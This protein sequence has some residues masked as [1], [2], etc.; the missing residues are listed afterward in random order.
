[1][2]AKKKIGRKAASPSRDQTSV[3][4]E[5][6]WFSFI[7]AHGSN[8]SWSGYV[9]SDGGPAIPGESDDGGSAEAGALA[10]GQN[11]GIW[12][13]IGVG[14]KAVIGCSKYEFVM[15]LTFSHLEECTHV[16]NVA[17]GSAL[18]AVGAGNQRSRVANAST[19]FVLVV[20]RC[21]PPVALAAVF[22]W[23][24]FFVLQCD[25][26]FCL[27][28]GTVSRILAVRII[29]FCYLLLVVRLEL[30]DAC[31]SHPASEDH[32]LCWLFHHRTFSRTIE[33]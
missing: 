17:S 20:D 24:R 18:I 23:A 25:M 31:Y 13:P 6:T 4:L 21:G 26:G 28:S 9:G 29:W 1:M 3:D 19:G 33:N 22:S 15:L 10:A 7:Y 14:A 32:S 16:Y 8:I 5:G 30:I 11:S 2:G 12:M 27:E